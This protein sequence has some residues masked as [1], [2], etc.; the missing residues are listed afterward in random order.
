MRFSSPTPNVYPVR[1][2]HPSQ[3]PGSTPHPPTGTILAGI[4]S[5]KHVYATCP[6]NPQH[7]PPHLPDQGSQYSVLALK[8]LLLGLIMAPRYGSNG[9]NTPNRNSPSEKSKGESPQFTRARKNKQIKEHL[10]IRSVGKTDL[11]MKR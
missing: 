5:I 3:L 6:L 11:S 9:I 1:T 4:S 2:R 8:Q 7:V 10:G